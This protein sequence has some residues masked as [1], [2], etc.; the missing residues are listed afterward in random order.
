M[1]SPH[2]HYMMQMQKQQD[3]RNRNMA[4]LS[5]QVFDRSQSQGHIQINPDYSIEVLDMDG[6][7]VDFSHH[8]DI[9]NHSPYILNGMHRKDKE[10]MER[11]LSIAYQAIFRQ[12][13]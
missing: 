4:I 1:F 7:C 8:P 10:L 2:M 13:Y 5:K 12:I 11:G 3:A 6:A 9:T